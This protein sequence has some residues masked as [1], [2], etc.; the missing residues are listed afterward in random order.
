M[1]DQA[2]Y[3]HQLARPWRSGHRSTAALAISVAP[4]TRTG[5]ARKKQLQEQAARAYRSQ[6]LDE[7]RLSTAS[8]VLAFLEAK[9][10]RQ[11]MR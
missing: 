11:S 7:N 8:E 1:T 5:Y 10:C 2:Y 4:F 9:I 6:K 3:R